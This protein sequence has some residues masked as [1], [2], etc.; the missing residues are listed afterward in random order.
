[1]S[2]ATSFDTLVVFLGFFGV[3]AAF[4]SSLIVYDQGDDGFDKLV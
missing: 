2:S 3:M 4:G 1:V